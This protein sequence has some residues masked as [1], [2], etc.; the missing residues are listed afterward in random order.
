MISLFSQLFLYRL[1]TLGV[2]GDNTKNAWE[3]NYIITS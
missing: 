2:L 1:A 3:G